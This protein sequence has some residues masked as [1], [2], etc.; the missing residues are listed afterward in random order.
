MK[1]ERLYGRA[2]GRS[3]LTGLLILSLLAGLTACG[4][5]ETAGQAEET[6][7]PKQLVTA[8]N[9]EKEPYILPEGLEEEQAD[10]SETV[11]VKADASGKPEEITVETVLKSDGT[12]GAIADYTTL[13]GIR[14]TD[15][16][17]EMTEE[18]EG[19]LTWENT[20]TDIKYEG[21][22]DAEL[23]VAVTVTYYLND[24]ETPAEEMAGANGKITVRF[25]Y[26]N[27]TAETVSVGDEEVTVPV[28]FTV[29]SL[30]YL[31]AQ[32]TAGVEVT[33]GEKISMEDAVLA[34]GCA[35]PGMGD[36]LKLSDYELTEEMDI[37]EYVEVSFYTAD[38]HLDFTATVI[39][40]GIMEKWKEEKLDDLDQ[41]IE[42]MGK[43]QEAADDLEDGTGALYDGLK[44]YQDYLIRYTD[45]VGEAADGISALRDGVKQLNDSKGALY[46]GAKALQSGLEQLN[47]ALTTALAGS[48]APSGGSHSGED[49]APSGSSQAGGMAE[50]L[51][52]AAALGTEAET[53]STYLANLGGDIAALYGY[54]AQAEAYMAA[55]ESYRADVDAY[56]E[57]VISYQES[58][59]VYIASEAEECE[60]KREAILRSLTAISQEGMSEED[61]EILNQ[62]IQAVSPDPAAP[63][64][65][66]W[67]L[68]AP[69]LEMDPPRFDE[70]VP[71]PIVPDFHMTEDGSRLTALLADMEKQLVIIGEGA[72]VLAGTVS[73][74]SD[75]MTRLAAMQQAVQQLAAGSRQLTEGVSAVNNAIGAISTGMDAL[76]DGAGQLR[77]AGGEMTDAF[78]DVADGMRELRNGVK[79]LNEKGIQELTKLA[80]E[81]L[82]GLVR[83]LRALKL[84]DAAYENF[85]GIL[86]GQTG[87]VVFI[88]ETEEISR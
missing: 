69:A 72:D 35:F 7:A 83:K 3:C 31:D 25:D 19:Y 38:F 8:E 21:K 87:Q 88:I 5:G 33:N 45:G 49:T 81:E 10:K 78:Q 26:E 12:A 43:L 29:M 77:E 16:G 86:D 48:A 36:C 74:V 79:E 54:V 46:E 56:T 61:Q 11:Y 4:S 30:L 50:M 75:M 64:Q 53:L 24:V 84:T 28:P 71:V 55:V 42:D 9:S 44:A 57:A 85:G 70:T 13:T 37:P 2:A 39:T 17:E 15:G 76:N 66:G 18:G 41:T 82:A 40:P 62:V 6:E 65:D 47:A 63:D 59:N 52:A 34:V 73:G 27:R 51:T 32:E 1:R 23:P 58:V 22:S 68:A 60:T 80:G 67:D 20:G 14:N